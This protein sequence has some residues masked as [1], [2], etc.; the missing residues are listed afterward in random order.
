MQNNLRPPVTS[1]ALDTAIGKPAQGLPLK[2]EQL[3]GEGKRTWLTLGS[4]E[5]NNDGRAP[6]LLAPGS[7]RATTVV[8]I[9]FPLFTPLVL[10]R[11]YIL[12]ST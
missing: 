4:S 6:S 9:V 7:V 11:F 8:N 2:L 3:V 5:T 10:D 1:H 12:K